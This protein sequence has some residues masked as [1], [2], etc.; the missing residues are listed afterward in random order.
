[1]FWVVVD[2]RKKSPFFGQWDGVAL[3]TSGVQSIYVAKG[4]A[5]GC[6][7]MSENCTL[8]INSDNYFS[9]NHG[10]GILW[11]D[12]ELDVKWP[13][14]HGEPVISAEHR[15]YPGFGLFK[16]QYGGV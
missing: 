10:H 6:L 7:S 5:H 2:L 13:L 9:P 16:S 8:F 3:S 14:A 15:S 4:F 12:P 1:M 11:N